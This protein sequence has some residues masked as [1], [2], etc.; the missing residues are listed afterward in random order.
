MKENVKDARITVRIPQ[1]I[2]DKMKDYCDDRGDTIS[3]F[4]LA[5]INEKLEKVGA[6]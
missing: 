6:K 3:D 2:K 5:A 1:E 4:V